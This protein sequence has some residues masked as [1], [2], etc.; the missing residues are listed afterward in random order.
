MRHR[1]TMLRL[2]G[3]AVT[4]LADRLKAKGLVAR[5]RDLTDARSVRLSL[6]EAGA[7]LVPILD[8]EADAHERAW[9][10]SLSYSELRQYKLTIA[11]ILQPA[12]IKSRLPRPWSNGRFWLQAKVAGIRSQVSSRRSKL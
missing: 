8:A 5:D 12:N 10:G 2:D 7:A 1:A 11:K 3:G 9:F 6:T 4:R